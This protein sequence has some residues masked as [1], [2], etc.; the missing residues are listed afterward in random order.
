[1]L[2]TKTRSEL[3]AAENIRRQGL[4]CYL[5]QLAP[6]P[7]GQVQPLFPGY[8]FARV[9]DQWRVLRSTFGVVDIVMQG[10]YPAVL[11][12]RE[13]EWIKSLEGVDGLVHLPDEPALERLNR[14]ERLRV[15]QGPFVGFGAICD[16]MKGT[17]RVYVL[18][19]VL[20]KST[21]VE[22]NVR[23]VSRD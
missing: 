8:L 17:D 20:G 2:R 5:P 11:R 10:E 6:K 12:D 9:V 19:N 23:D 3:W 14:G 21:R 22:M 1:V 18:L 7:T 4:E 15:E 13:I 16:G